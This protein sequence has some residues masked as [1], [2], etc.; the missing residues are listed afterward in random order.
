MGYVFDPSVLHECAKVGIDMPLEEGF[1]AI[2]AALAER[3]PKHIH[4]GERSWVLNNAGGAMGQITLLHSSLTEYILLFGSPIGT[5]GHSGRYGAEVWDF[6]IKGEMWTYV[7][8]DL[9]RSVYRPGDGAYLSPSQAK[10]YRLPDHGWMLEYSRGF[11]PAMLPFGL[12][13]SL[14]STLDVKTFGKT[15]K[16]YTKLVV[17]SLLKGKI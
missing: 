7:E 10:G 11:I 14:T 16:N 9:E 12:A 5:E 17:G 2:T 6:M 4:T 15:V 3:Y 1:D 13:D 8:G